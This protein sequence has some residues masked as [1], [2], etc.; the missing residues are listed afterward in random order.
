MKKLAVTLFSAI[1]LMSSLSISVALAS[2][3]NIMFT[4]PQD[5][6]PGQ[7]YEYSYTITVYAYQLNTKISCNAASITGDLNQFVD[8]EDNLVNVNRTFTGKVSVAI[9][10]DAKPGDKYSII[11]TGEYNCLNDTDF[12]MTNVDINYSYPLTVTIP[13]QPTPEPTPTPTPEVSQA[14]ASTPAPTD[15]VPPTIPTTAPTPK[16][17]KTERPINSASPVATVSLTPS[18]APSVSTEVFN[19]PADSPSPLAT[20]MP[21]VYNL[22]LDMLSK[23]GTLS[24]TMTAADSVSATTLKALKAKQATL[25]IDYGSYSCTIDGAKLGQISD[26]DAY[27]FAVMMGKDAAVSD[28]ANGL[29]IYQLHFAQTGEMPGCFTYRFAASNNLPGDTLY[30]YCYHALSELAEYKQSAVVDQDGNVSFDIYEG[31]SYFVTASLLEIIEDEPG[32]ALAAP[33]NDAA[34]SGSESGHWLVFAVIFAVIGVAAV[35]FMHIR[36]IGI[37]KSR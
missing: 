12:S 19:S 15:D 20:P 30:L 34:D 2:G 23:G 37:F 10:K 24:M 26:S 3:I 22:E 25:N 36:R 1:V 21:P 17:A 14:P 18:P 35:G 13:V 4:G 8:D 28:A 7:T 5:V 32:I 27:Q 16:P 9:S 11:V 31:Q 33:V 29:D 6:Q